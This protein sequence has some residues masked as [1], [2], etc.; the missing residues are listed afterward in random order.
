MSH[1]TGS[2]LSR[3]GEPG[4]DDEPFIL[5][6]S[7]DYSS[8]LHRAANPYRERTGRYAHR[9]CTYRPRTGRLPVFDAKRPQMGKSEKRDHFQGL[10]SYM[11]AAARPA[12]QKNL[13][14]LAGKFYIRICTYFEFSPSSDFWRMWSMTWVTCPARSLKA[15]IISDR[16]PWSTS[17]LCRSR[18]TSSRSISFSASRVWLRA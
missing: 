16:S 18:A 3:M 14:T 15:A 6:N 10:A 12:V 17:A 13:P 9:I 5:I 7:T 1:M 8:I 11:T 4:S 2:S